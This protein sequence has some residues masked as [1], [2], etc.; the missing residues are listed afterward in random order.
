MANYGDDYGTAGRRTD[1]YGNPV[2]GTD[3]HGNPV[4]HHAG[5][6]Y[7]TTGGYGTGTHGTTGGNGTGVGIH[8]SGEQQHGTLNR[9]GSS[10]S[11]SRLLYISFL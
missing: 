4:G 2:G 7:G 11:V 1:E 10:S 3:Q 9:S 5:G 6:D 8:G